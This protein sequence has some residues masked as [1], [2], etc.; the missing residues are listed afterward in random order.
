VRVGV[1][2]RAGTG[3][4]RLGTPDFRRVVCGSRARRNDVYGPL[5][6]RSLYR[7]AERDARGRDAHA[8]HRDGL[9]RRPRREV[10]RIGR[11]V[12]LPPDGA[13]VPIRRSAPQ[14]ALG[15]AER[16]HDPPHL[17]GVDDRNRLVKRH[18]HEPRRKRIDR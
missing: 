13:R 2:S 4:G 9:A 14:R 5:D 17:V 11:V 18:P 3:V 1:E 10:R 6:D 16:S 12:A 7:G 15:V 8:P